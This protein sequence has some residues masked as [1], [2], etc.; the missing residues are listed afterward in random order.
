MLICENLFLL[1][2]EDDGRPASGIRLPNPALSGALLT[3]LVLTELVSLSPDKHAKV[4]PN[5]P[6]PLRQYHPILLEAVRQLQSIKP[7]RARE[8]IAQDQLKARTLIGDYLV[9]VGTAWKEEAKWLGMRPARYAIPDGRPE[10]A[11]RTHLASVLRGESMASIND[12][13]VLSILKDI[14]G[15]QRTFRSD[16]PEMS[17]KQVRARIDSI[18]EEMGTTHLTRPV[19]EAIAQINAAAA[20]AAGTTV[21]ISSS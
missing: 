13:I 2:T 20:V 6:H 11:L 10:M 18:M 17:R 14:R 21:A 3:D 5:Q 9:H 15:A 8:L 12:A 1:L 19:R 7:K 16:V 4:L